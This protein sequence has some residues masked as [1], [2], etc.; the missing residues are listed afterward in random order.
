[1]D[2]KDEVNVIEMLRGRTEEDD[3]NKVLKS[4]FGGYTKKSVQEYFAAVRKQQQ[5]S[6]ETFQKNL[7][8]LFDEKEIL[9]KSNETLI[10][11]NNKLSAEYDNL[12]ESLKN[13]KLEE[14]EFSAQDICSLKSTIISLEEEVKI[15]QGEKK[16]L[17]KKVVQLEQNIIELTQA[18]HNSKEETQAQK[19][20]LKV[21][22]HELKK[23]RDTVADISRELAEEK[24]EVKFL[25]GTMTD[26]KYAELNMKINELHEQLAAQTEV[27]SKQKSESDLKEKTVDTLN[28]EIATLKQRLTS[29]IQSVQNSNMQNDKLLVANDLLK[30][31]LQEEY[32]KSIELINEKA[33]IAIEKLISQKNL[34]VAEAKITSMELQIEKIKNSLD[35][36]NIQNKSIEI[37]LNE[38]LYGV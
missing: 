34:S 28:E 14:S 23:Q 32:K 1:M 37:F 38:N 30:S 24:M 5:I 36:K 12:Y 16:S 22:R 11:R 19:E 29:M 2:K 31:Q 3:L 21:E 15:I 6:Q 25:K 18:L 17:E 4:T 10:A 26:G 35:V 33:N 7:Q 13:M 20:I 8:A 27:I 9:R